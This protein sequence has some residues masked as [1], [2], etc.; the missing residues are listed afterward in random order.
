MKV[1]FCNICGEDFDLEDYYNNLG[2]HTILGYGSKHDGRNLEMD[3]CCQCMDKLIQKC[4]ISPLSMAST[5]T[6]LEECGAA[7]REI[8]IIELDNDE[9]PEDGANEHNKDWIQ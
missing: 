3:I 2:V 6:S 5:H 1:T 9:D 7:T 8:E 4:R